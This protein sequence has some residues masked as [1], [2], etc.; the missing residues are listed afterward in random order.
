MA[1]FFEQLGGAPAVAAFINGYWTDY[2]E[3][4]FEE[5]GKG[6]GKERIEVT[7]D[8]LP[9]FATASDPGPAHSASPPRQ[10]SSHRHDRATASVPD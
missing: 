7:T 10:R 9:P 8:D 5:V 4:C 1:K 6:K 2:V 3:E